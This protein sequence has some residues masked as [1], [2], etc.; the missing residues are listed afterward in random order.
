MIKAPEMLD[1]FPKT[2]YGIAIERWRLVPGDLSNST[3]IWTQSDSIQ[4]DNAGPALRI[5]ACNLI[6][7]SRAASMIICF[8]HCRRLDGYET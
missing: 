5:S 6:D 2:V 3:T 8:A 1:C 7:G 4:H